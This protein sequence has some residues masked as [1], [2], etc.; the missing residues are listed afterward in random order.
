M[1]EIDKKFKALKENGLDLGN[2]LGPEENADSGGKVRRYEN[3]NIYWCR[4]TGAHEVHGGILDLY[5]KNGGPGNSPL[6]GGRD[7]MYPTS[8]E[9][10]LKGYSPISYSRFE[11]GAIYFVP[12]TKGV[13]LYGGVYNFYQRASNLGLPLIGNFNIA[14]GQAA[15]FE[16][17]IIF[18][19]DVTS[20]ISTEALVA[21]FEFPLMGKPGIVSLGDDPSHKLEFIV[22]WNELKKERYNEL[23]GWNQNI[24]SELIKG[25]FALAPVGSQFSQLQLL[26][27]KINKVQETNFFTDV[28]ASFKVNPENAPGLK[29][30]TLYD[31]QLN[32]KVGIPY[33]LSPHCFYVKTDWDN[34]GLLHIT[35]IH[36]NA[37]N[38]RYREKLESKGLNDAAKNY[39]NYQDNFADFIKYANKLHTLGLAD[40][41]VA[42][43]DL[44]DY[45]AEDTDNYGE[46]NFER[47]RRMILGE[48][49]LPGMQPTE[50]LMIPIF[51]T[52]GNH[53]YRLAS[54][55]L[56]ANF[57]LPTDKWDRALNEHSTLNLF[58]SEAIELQDGKIPTYTVS[59]I[60]GAGK[61]VQYDRFD[62]RYIYFKKYLT[63]ERT[64]VVKLGKHRLVVMDTKMDNGIPDDFDLMTL[65]NAQI[66][67]PGFW[68]G[69]IG[70]G[71]PATRKLLSGIGPDSV[72]FSP[73][74]LGML[75]NAIVEAGEDGIVIVGMHCP[76]I[77]P[78]GEY[79]YYHRETIHPTADPALTDAYIKRSKMSDGVSWK[80]TGTP[81]FKD[82]KIL[83]GMDAGVI[84]HGGE[85]FLKICA[86]IGLA[87]PVDLVLC[88]HHHDRVEYR[89]KWNNQTN[90]MEYYM[91]FYSENPSSYYHTISSNG[92]GGTIELPD[93][94]PIKIEIEQGAALPVTIKRVNDHRL[95]L[96]YGIAK[97]PP[98]AE[99]LNSSA[100]QKEWWQKYRPLLAQTAALGPIDPRQRFGKFYKLEPPKLKY[101]P[102]VESHIVP[103]IP[104]GVNVEELPSRLVPPTF[105]GFRLM[106][107]KK[108][109][110]VKIRYVV[111]NELRKNNFNSNWE[112][113]LRGPGRGGVDLSTVRNPIVTRHG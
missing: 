29:E 33:S 64:Y 62:N 46:E 38:Q 5:L 40:A 47:F 99:P 21:G 113:D 31:L 37:R 76:V 8:D 86:G 42:T 67:G 70:G 84:A 111:L 91:D 34:F 7:L 77:S 54:Y 53:D 27:L 45:V 56:V 83:D 50:K 28:L 106:Q 93:K 43:G 71:L 59:N 92:A 89:V 85:D 18:R 105:Q 81:F 102:V 49:F 58:E 101:R 4:A 2:A 30:R 35:D 22:R 87:R 112:S 55:D 16:R 74:E 25:M 94:S 39:S 107:I 36:I 48:P 72:G 63:K 44:I 103:D 80:K 6:T 68:E 24:F 20:G 51:M 17:G 26:E 78:R 66:G 65:I 52:F 79:A 19:P 75:R 15:F 108:G 57:D 88:G 60:E 104:R 61:M 1:T 12:G 9:E 23:V 97:T 95:N 96:T 98:F 90:I 32:L 69:Q 13:V 3:G 14:G 110:I 100:N 109:T 41:V 11:N 82:G 10:L 73:E